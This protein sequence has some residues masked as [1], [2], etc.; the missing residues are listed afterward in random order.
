M[1]RHR[2]RMIAVGVGDEDMGHGLAAHGVE[3]R[4]DVGLVERPRIDDRDLAA[5]DDVGHACP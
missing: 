5:A 1:R 3:Q 4:G 2:R